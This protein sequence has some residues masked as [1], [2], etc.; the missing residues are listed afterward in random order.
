MLSQIKSRCYAILLLSALCM[1]Q[2][3]LRTVKIQEPNY[4]S[5]KH[6]QTSQQDSETSND[7]GDILRLR[8]INYLRNLNLY[9]DLD[10]L[11]TRSK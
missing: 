2:I 8:V 3:Y 5:P 10:T 4:W 9:R 7:G 11:K 1:P 6:V